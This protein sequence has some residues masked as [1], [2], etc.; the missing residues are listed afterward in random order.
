MRRQQEKVFEEQQKLEA[1]RLEHARQMALVQEQ[2]DTVIKAQREGQL[3]ME[4]HDALE[5]RKADLVKALTRFSEA[6]ARPLASGLTSTIAGSTVPVESTRISTEISAGSSNKESSEA[7]DRAAATKRAQLGDSAPA[8]IVQK[9]SSEE[10]WQRQK[11][12]EG[13]SNEALDQI[14]E[15]IGLEEVKTQMLRIKSRIDTTIRQGT[16]VKDERFNIALLGNPG[17][18]MKPV[19]SAYLW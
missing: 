4:R 9:S 8:L 16:N 13:A 5:Q 7:V 12:V 10:E 6:Q 1:E 3:S 11:D 18:G 17:T 15:M 19:L 2:I 14:M